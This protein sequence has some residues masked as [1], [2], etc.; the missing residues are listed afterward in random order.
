M[1]LP[2]RLPPIAGWG[3]LV[4]T[5][6]WLLSL[7]AALIAPLG[8][9]SLR[10]PAIGTTA[11]ALSLA[12][13]LLPPVPNPAQRR[14]EVPDGAMYQGTTLVVPLKVLEMIGASGGR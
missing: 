12:V 10:L 11:E 4:F 7:A 9:A 13:D 2:E 3:R 5:V 14:F 1:R 8:G 6:V